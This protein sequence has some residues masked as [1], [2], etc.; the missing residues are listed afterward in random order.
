MIRMATAAVR[1][2]IAVLQGQRPEHLV[3]PEIYRE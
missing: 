3:N 1:G 2:V